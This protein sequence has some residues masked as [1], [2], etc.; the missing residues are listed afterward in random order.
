MDDSFEFH[1]QHTS[2]ELK[3]QYYTFQ[4]IWNI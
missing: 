4:A 2:Q 3:Q 1:L